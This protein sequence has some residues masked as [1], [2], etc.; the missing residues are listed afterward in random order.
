MLSFN[1]TLL[2]QIKAESFSRKVNLYS[3]SINFIFRCCQ[4]YPVVGPTREE[5]QADEESVEEAQ[6]TRTSPLEKHHDE[7]EDG[8]RSSSHSTNN[9]HL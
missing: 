1:I 9:T 7:D 8:E 4:S 6:R 3:V 5:D 2:A